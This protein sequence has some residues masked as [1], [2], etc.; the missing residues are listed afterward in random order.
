MRKLVLQ[1]INLLIRQFQPDKYL[2]QV[3][4]NGI[5]CPMKTSTRVTIALL[6]VAVVGAVGTVAGLYARG[7]RFNSASYKLAANG[8]LS[9][10]SVPGGA[11]V[12]VNG[13]LKTATDAT[14]PLPPGTYDVE[15]K[16]EGFTTWSKRLVIDK[17]IVTET[18]AYLFRRTPSITAITFS[19]VI[20]PVTTSNLTK[21]AYIVPPQTKQDENAGLWVL[22]TVDLPI[23]F[24]RDPRRITDG[25]LT[26]ATFDWSPDDRQ[27]LLTTSKGIF[28]LDAGQFTPQNQ[29]V[30]ITESGMKDLQAQWEL[31]DT[32]KLAS[33]LKKLPTELQ[34]ILGK[35][36][37]HITPS[38]DKEMVLYESTADV[39]IPDNLIPQLPGSSTQQQARNLTAGNIYVY[40]V[41][42]D[43]NFL[44]E[45]G[46][47]GAILGPTK[48]G[49]GDK[50]IAWFPTSR[51]LVLAT[52]NSVTIMDY[53]GT[54]R[55]EVFSGTYAAPSAFPTLSKDRLMIL[56]NLGAG[57]NTPDLYSLSLN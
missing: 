32:K 44:V 54:N 16:K 38:P 31:E 37:N 29:L 53:D 3:T 45:Q 39:T 56:T 5:I 42:E 7:Y 28:L 11:Q 46:S 51:H 18:T 19:G 14:L 4:Q 2:L 36:A 13:E 21:I 41:K 55:Q 48:N 10:K 25:D 8:L 27:I 1:H 33:E 43:R 52:P 15:V 26:G 57:A 24:S 22:E 23:G 12:F 50:R 35:Y 40:D 47:E 30:N 6:T 49:G 34:S 20:E 17:E 9:V